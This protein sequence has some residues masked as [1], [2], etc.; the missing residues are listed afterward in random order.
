MIP[1]LALFPLVFCV[2]GDDFK[3]NTD[4]PIL[5]GNGFL[6]LAESFEFNVNC[7]GLH[8]FY[9]GL[10]KYIVIEIRARLSELGIM[11]A[12]ELK[13]KI[14]AKIGIR[15]IRGGSELARVSELKQSGK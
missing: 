10:A 14:P 9:C 13:F 4:K 6:E 5:R 11:I 15:F 3:P 8:T 7:R 1:F 2:I 12:Q